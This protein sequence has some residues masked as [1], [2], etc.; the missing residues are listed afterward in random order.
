MSNNESQSPAESQPT[1]QTSPSNSNVLQVAASNSP[2]KTASGTP[3]QAST[4]AS[5][6]LINGMTIPDLI[7]DEIRHNPDFK[8]ALLKAIFSQD[9][10]KG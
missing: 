4:A 7:V 2:A 9:N 1:N 8:K 3:Q 5:G 10:E 6:L